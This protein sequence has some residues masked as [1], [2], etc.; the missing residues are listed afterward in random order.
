MKK[1]VFSVLSLAMIFVVAGTAA[2]AEE[3]SEAALEEYTAD[4]ADGYA[5]GYDAEYAAEYSDYEA[6][7]EFVLWE[8]WGFES[9]EEFLETFGICEEEYLW[10]E[11]DERYWWEWD[12]R[13]RR[14]RE[15]R[16]QQQRYEREAF[17]T[18]HDGDP[19]KFNVM[20]DGRF[21]SFYSPESDA[22]WSWSVLVPVRL[23]FEELGARVDF[24]AAA[25][26]IIIEY[27]GISLRL[28][29]GEDFA[30]VTEAW[31]D[32]RF[33]LDDFTT[34][35]DGVSFVDIFLVEAF[36]YGVVMDEIVDAAVIVDTAAL[37]E[38]ANSYFTIFN[39]LIGGQVDI[40]PSGD[41]VSLT[42]IEVAA[43]ATEF[44]TLDG[45]RVSTFGVDAEIH[46]DGRNFTVRGTLDV[47]E[48]F[49]PQMGWFPPD[50]Y[51]RAELLGSGIELI[52]NYGDDVLYIYAPLFSLIY[53]EFPV[54]GWLA[55]RGFGEY[56]EDYITD[57]Y[58]SFI[59]D[60][61]PV[62]N[63]V[64]TAITSEL[65]LFLW[66]ASSR[67]GIFIFEEFA[68]SLEFH[69]ELI[70]DEAFSRNEFGHVLVVTYEDMLAAAYEH[71]VDTFL[72]MRLHELR[73]FDINLFVR[74]INDEIAAASGS[75]VF[76]EDFWSSAIR[77]RVEF[78]INAN[79]I[80]FFAEEHDRNR[81][82]MSI[83]ISA[84]TEQSA[85]PVPG[86]PP[87]GARIVAIEDLFPWWNGNEGD[88][89]ELGA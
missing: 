37:R 38:E 64:G 5:A 6:A 55:F 74:F 85:A 77:N 83:E 62:R 7:S 84:V 45:N 49:S 28:P 39:R 8:F 9:L 33:W 61:M 14:E 13:W 79:E 43:T 66:W 86:A 20:I 22:H 50:Y 70:G 71:D 72:R 47:Q 25:S 11:E 32:W 41:G 40:L 54:D 82:V 75:M 34:I 78:V 59:R 18:L 52:F 3:T 53:P 10:W 80:S 51:S 26:E 44:D 15:E 1:F 87:D 4:Y 60:F 2:L 21:I 88:L 48:L 76:R 35:I 24:N 68:R 89:V 31:G 81:S 67:H 12:Q 56:I 57:I 58:S 16:L 42:T 30:I 63:D 36:G 73:E 46:T 19:D 23:L 27:N 69:R 29:V 17:I 65:G